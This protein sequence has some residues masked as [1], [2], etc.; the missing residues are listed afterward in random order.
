[1][2]RIANTN[3]QHKQAEIM[4]PKQPIHLS[5]ESLEASR[6]QFIF[7]LKTFLSNT[8]KHRLESVLEKSSA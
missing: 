8:N 4:G 5:P 7:L 6:A 3:K 1:M 2:K